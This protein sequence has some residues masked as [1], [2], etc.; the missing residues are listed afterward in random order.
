MSLMDQA[1][2]EPC[3]VCGKNRPALKFD[4]DLGG[5]V[6]GECLRHVQQAERVMQGH[7]FK[8]SKHKRNL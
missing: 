6:C 3:V 1:L 2:Q 4:N 7:A 5:H 8:T